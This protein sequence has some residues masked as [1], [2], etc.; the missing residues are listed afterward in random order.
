MGGEATDAVD[1]SPVG[2]AFSFRRLLGLHEHAYGPWRPQW[3]QR[4]GTDRM[5]TL[6]CR[7]CATCNGFDIKLETSPLPETGFPHGLHLD[8]PTRDKPEA[9]ELQD[10]TA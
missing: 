1:L 2:R 4:C 8:V 7:D 9:R 3:A 6:L 5:T 10:S